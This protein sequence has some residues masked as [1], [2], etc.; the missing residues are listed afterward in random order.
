[1]LSVI[2]FI[3]IFVVISQ[4]EIGDLTSGQALFY[5]LY[6]LLMLHHTSKKY[7]DYDK[8][9]KEKNKKGGRK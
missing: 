8:Y 5:G 1:M 4:T 3:F 2:S 7:W 6:W 9:I